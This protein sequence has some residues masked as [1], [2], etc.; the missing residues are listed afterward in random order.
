MRWQFIASALAAAT[1]IDAAP[2]R[3]RRGAPPTQ[4]LAHRGVP[5]DKWTRDGP[6][7]KQFASSNTTS[8]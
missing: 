3:Y 7:A 6:V 4:P 1:A 8:K 2:D 5:F